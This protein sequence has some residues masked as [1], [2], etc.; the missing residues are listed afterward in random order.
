MTLKELRIKKGL[1]QA[2][3]AEQTGLSIRLIQK[4]EQNAQDLNRVYAITIYRLAKA[5][6]CRYEDL[7][8]I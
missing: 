1:T 3:L 7:L 5:L 2:E 8:T 4:Y 6:D